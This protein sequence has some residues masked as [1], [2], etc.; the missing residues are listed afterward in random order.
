MLRNWEAYTMNCLNFETMFEKGL[1]GVKYWQLTNG[2][3]TFPP[4]LG[5]SHD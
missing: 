2:E 4:G 5:W 1:D 3:L